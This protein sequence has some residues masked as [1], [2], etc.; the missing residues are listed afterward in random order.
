MN[1]HLLRII[2]DSIGHLFCYFKIAEQYR[3]L[4]LLYFIDGWDGCFSAQYNV[5][6]MVISNGIGAYGI[7]SNM[8]MNER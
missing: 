4:L 1:R 5:H 2:K 8:N 7:Q 3:F 6:G